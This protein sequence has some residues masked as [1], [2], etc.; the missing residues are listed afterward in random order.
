MSTADNDGMDG[1]TPEEIAALTAPDDEDPNATQGALEDKTAATELAASTEAEEDNKAGGKDGAEE[2]KS[3]DVAGANTD[4]AADVAAAAAAPAGADPAATAASSES[5]P[6]PGAPIYVAEAPADAEAK[7]AEIATKKGDLL[8]L[9]DDGEITAKEYQSKVDALTKDERAIER[10]QDRAE[11]AADMEQQRLKNQW[12]TDCNAFMG[13]HKDTYDGEANKEVFAH[14]NET[15]IAFAK[16]PRNAGISGP[17]LLA[18]AHKAVMAERGTP[19]ADTPAAAKPAPAAPKPGAPKPALPP[20]MS[21]MPSASSN[22]PGEGRFA[23][24]DR[25]QTE[26]PAAYEAALAKLSGAEQDAYL[27]A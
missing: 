1:L 19:V 5:S 27:S 12:D 23:S 13:K 21:K 14:L 2:K 10:A 25:L 18:K 24:L 11:I 6:A 20:D 9:F 16:M 22:D 15:I 4:P 26:N 7:L 17:E 3:G 8:T